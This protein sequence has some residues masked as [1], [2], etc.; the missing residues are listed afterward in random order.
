[1]HRKFKKFWGPSLLAFAAILF[2]TAG[3]DQAREK[4]AAAIKPVTVEEVTVEVNEKID[5]E[6]F[7]EAR[8]EGERFLDGKADASGALAWAIAKSCAQTGDYDKA[9]RYAEQALGT[10]AVTAPQAMAEPLMEP[11]RNDIRFVS[12]LAGIGGTQTS[13]AEAKNPVFTHQANQ[14]TPPSTAIRMDAQGIEVKAG[15][16]VVKLPN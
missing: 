5:Q 4:M 8:I 3:C 16:I 2:L 14:H 11:V 6:K 13:P 10:H 15:D 12:L 1:M 7:E 9:I